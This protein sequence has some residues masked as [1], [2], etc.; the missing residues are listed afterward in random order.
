MFGAS[1]ALQ[2]YKHLNAALTDMHKGE[3]QHTDT[4]AAFTVTQRLATTQ[5][6]NTWERKV[7]Q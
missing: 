6:Q 1:V 7:T 3:C 5:S 2:K 4:S